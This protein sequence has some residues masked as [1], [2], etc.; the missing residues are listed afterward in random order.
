[1]TEQTIEDGCWGIADG[2]SSR[3]LRVGT[4]RYRVA[5]TRRARRRS[6]PGSTSSIRLP[7]LLGLTNAGFRPKTR[8][9]QSIDSG[10]GTDALDGGRLP[11]RI[12]E[13]IRGPHRLRRSH[14]RS[15]ADG[16]QRVARVSG[17]GWGLPRSGGCR[18]YSL[19]FTGHHKRMPTKPGGARSGLHPPLRVGDDRRVTQGGLYA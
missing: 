11:C 19:N 8:D 4:H 15:T 16:A 3:Q 13:W 14:A 5:H 9:R 18:W 7:S 1:V 10:H 17:D 12:G 6:R 2:R